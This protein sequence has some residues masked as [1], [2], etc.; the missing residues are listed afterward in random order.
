MIFSVPN[1]LLLLTYYK[2]VMITT[3]ENKSGQFG[4]KILS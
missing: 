3:F 2:F 1:I 4:A